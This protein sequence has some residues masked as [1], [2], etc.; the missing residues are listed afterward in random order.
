[1]NNKKIKIKSRSKIF[2]DTWKLMSFWIRKK[3]ADYR[4]YVH[5]Y[6][7]DIVLNYKQANAG[8]YNHNK[9]DFDPRNIKVQCVRCN[10]YL[11]G[12]LG[13]YA[14]R[15]IREH[16]Q[17]WLDQLNKDCAEKG[18]SYKIPELLEIQESL[19]KEIDKIKV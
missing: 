4:D 5:C 18:N 8:H 10:K 3:E 19:K 1:M 6:T 9:L 16:G 13:K 12:N 17:E 14:E 15:L 2:K 7:C 11:R